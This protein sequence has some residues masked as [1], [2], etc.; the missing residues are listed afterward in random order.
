VNWRA[1]LA[2]LGSIWLILAA[3]LL[4]PMTVGLAADPGNLRETLAFFVS[5]AVTAAVGWAARSQAHEKQTAIGRREGFAVVTFGWITA[6]L[7]GMAP[8]LA[9]GTLGVTDG[10]FEVMSGFTT[11]GATVLGPSTLPIESLSAGLQFWRCMTQWLG[12][13]GIVVLSVALLSVMGVGGYRL[14][15]AETPGGVAF[16]KDAPRISEAAGNLWKIYVVISAL[17]VLALV[18]CGM[19]LYDAT[20]H[21]FT[22]MSTGGFSSHTRSIAY[23]GPAAQ[24]VIILFMF[25][26]GM[27]FALHAQIARGK[28]KKLFK[29]PEFRGYT[30]ILL[31]AG[32]VSALILT[33]PGS[34]E[35]KLRA[36]LFQVVSIGT[37]TGYATVDFDHWPQI[38]RL[39]L[40]LL[41]FVGGSMGSTGGG[42]KVARIIVYGKVITREL[43]RLVYPSGVRPI[44]VGGKVMDRALVSNI[45]GFGVLYLTIF[46][47]GTAVVALAGYDL[48]TSSSASAAALGNIGPGLARVGATQD[49]G[50]LPAA[51]KWVLSME[52]L[53]GRLEIYSVL[54]L[55]T[56]WAWKR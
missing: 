37:T 48:V 2:L 27:N 3:C 29:D 9:T 1:V 36:G 8:F 25:L 54:V 33:S 42:I 55:L 49:F 24:W 16:E 17:E 46:A 14:V 23:F 53:L 15:K 40:L 10:F 5:A 11:T 50:H 19:S 21:T 38:L 6:V 52:M 7:V 43:H 39:A 44:R 34:L 20:C 35:G 28:L 41:M 30:F 31:G 22:T 13:M 45:L 12:G 32:L 51:V 4:V 18:A 56:P 47:V 26:A